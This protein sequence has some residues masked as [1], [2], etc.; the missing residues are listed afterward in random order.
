VIGA[1]GTGSAV[2]LYLAGAGLHTL[3][4]CESDVVEESNLHRQVLYT[5]KH[6]GARKAPIASCRVSDSGFTNSTYSIHPFQRVPEKSIYATGH[7]TH[8][9][10]Y[11]VVLDCTDR[12]SVHDDIVGYYVSKKV[13]VVQG[14]IQGLIGRVMT[15][16]H[17]TPCWRCLHPEKPTVTKEGPRGTLGPVCGVIG[18]LMAMEALRILLGH[19]PGLAGEMLVYSAM[20]SQFERMTR[21][22][23]PACSCREVIP[24]P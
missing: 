7:T 17:D 24:A 9:L 21:T 16:T 3:N 11:D 22:F 14:T 12:W 4:I 18:S 8:E 13:P 20:K 15:F 5:D 2:I 1:G 6:V 23:D 10:Q 19:G